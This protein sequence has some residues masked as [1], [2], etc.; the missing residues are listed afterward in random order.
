MA[1]YNEISAAFDSIFVESA[2][3]QEV[4]EPVEEEIE[5]ADG[6]GEETAEEQEVTEPAGEQSAEENA[7]FA[8]LRRKHEQELAQA[9]AEAEEAMKQTMQQEYAGM[10]GAL[11][12]FDPYSGKKVETAEEFQ[13]Y[14]KAIS[15]DRQKQIEE[16]LDSSDITKDEL[17]S[18]INSHPE[19]I[20]ARETN[21]RLAALERKMQQEADTKYFQAEIAEIQKVDPTIKGY[22]DIVDDL[23]ND[24]FKAMIDRGYK[25]SDAYFLLHK[26]DILN[27]QAEMNRQEAINTLRGKEHL[28]K[29]S[30]HGEAGYIATSE[31]IAEYQRLNPDRSVEEI[32]NFIARDRKRMGL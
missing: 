6:D 2:E 32:R 11:E 22:D 4:A 13:E 18:Y 27:R 3:K 9:R 10:F 17:N 7:K 26:G 25:I 16:K 12:L 14:V 30:S 5:E 23:K 29:S 21:E 19:V 20:K 24:D 8:A 15:E 28:K 1:D 31:E